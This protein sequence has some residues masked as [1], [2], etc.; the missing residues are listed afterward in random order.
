MQEAFTKLQNIFLANKM[1]ITPKINKIN[2]DLVNLKLE[3][4]I[5]LMVIYKNDEKTIYGCLKN[6]EKTFSKYNPRV[7]LLD[8]GSDDRTNSEIT[9]FKGCSDLNIIH[10]NSISPK[11]TAISENMSKITSLDFDYII[12]INPNDTYK[13]KS[14]VLMNI[15]SEL[16]KNPSSIKIGIGERDFMKNHNCIFHKI[17]NKIINILFNLK[18]N[19]YHANDCLSDYRILSKELFIKFFSQSLNISNNEIETY[20]N[21][22]IIKNNI[23]PV[24][25]CIDFK[26]YKHQ[27]NLTDKITFFNNFKKI[28][29]LN[30]ELLK[31]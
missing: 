30:K 7:F 17:G 14:D 6:I 24:C 20:I 22:Y 4:K 28:I 9:F 5:A 2:N 23:K 29:N 16:D 12:F 11:I 8:N 3:P 25:F 18:N 13:I 19:L 27:K 26:K 10:L 31:F 1:T 21:L 15:L